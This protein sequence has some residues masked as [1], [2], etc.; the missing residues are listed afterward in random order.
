MY[1][2]I[3]PVTALPALWMICSR[4]APALTSK[5]SCPGHLDCTFQISFSC[6]SLANGCKPRSSHTT[7]FPGGSGED[8]TVTQGESR[9]RSF[10]RVTAGVSTPTS[11]VLKV[12]CRLFFDLTSTSDSDLCL[13]T[14]WSCCSFGTLTSVPGCKGS[15]HSKRK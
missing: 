4:E 14:Q 5:S 13:I 11:T 2:A 3:T 7:A 9:L 10:V 15:F 1:L 12:G 8:R 6:S